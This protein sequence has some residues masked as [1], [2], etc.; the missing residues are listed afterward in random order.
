[1]GLIWVNV[2]NVSCSH[3]SRI[4]GKRKWNG[5]CW[6]S[7][8]KD[9]WSAEETCRCVFLHA[10]YRTGENSLLSL[11]CLQSAVACGACSSILFCMVEKQVDKVKVEVMQYHDL[12]AKRVLS[13]PSMRMNLDIPESIGLSTP[14]PSA[15]TSRLVDLDWDTGRHAKRKY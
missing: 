5:Q 15:S 1:M 7:S 8:E 14:A 13:S 10:P 6:I 12:D 4:R 2:S 9:G 3:V 11:M